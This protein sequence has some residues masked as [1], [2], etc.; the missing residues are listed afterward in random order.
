[1]AKSVFRK[2]IEK[3]Q[4]LVPCVFDC[5]SAHAAELIG[6]KATMLSGFAI[7]YSM[8]GLPDMAMATIDE[9]V[10]AT[11]HITN[12]TDCPLLIDGDDGYAESPAVVYRNMKRLIKAGAQGVTIEDSTGIRG[13]ERKVAHVAA[14]NKEPFQDALVS[15]EV[16][17]SKIKAAVDACAG[18]D[19]L[20]IARTNCF[21]VF[22]LDE[23]VDRC[24][25]AR[26]LGAEL[27]MICG[28]G[29]KT[30]DDAK[31]VGKHDPG[32]KMWPDIFSVKGKPNIV[33][34]EVEPYGFNSVTCHVFEKGMMY[35]VLK[36]AHENMKRG[37]TR[38]S[39]AHDMGG[40]LAAEQSEVL[41]MK[42][43]AWA[44]K[45]KAFAAR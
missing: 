26:E 25:R 37:S 16:W 6:Y 2:M 24:R 10:F 20:V 23:A 9:L 30:L 40:L 7:S 42:R 17:L 35:G 15:R 11:E 14:G 27:T 43:L 29:V 3:E 44:R 28:G 36:Y 12:M 32:A 33:M 31:Y 19:C 18:T 21:P 1:M 8:D 4:V 5:L 13:F 34:E 38:F 22:G 39:Q 45:A 41:A